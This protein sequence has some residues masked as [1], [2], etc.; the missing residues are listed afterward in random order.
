M[1][2]SEQPIVT[3]PEWMVKVLNKAMDDL[4]ENRTLYFPGEHRV[5]FDGWPVVLISPHNPGDEFQVW[6]E[7][8]NGRRWGITVDRTKDRYFRYR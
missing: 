2:A 8:Y 1:S 5:Q 4:L 7:E 3:C 6:A